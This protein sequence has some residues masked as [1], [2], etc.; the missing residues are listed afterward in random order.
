MEITF[1]KIPYED[2]LAFFKTRAELSDEDERWIRIQYDFMKEPSWIRDNRYEIYCPDNISIKKGAPFVIP[3]GFK[4][5]IDKSNIGEINCYGL[6]E[7]QQLNKDNLVRHIVIAGIATSN[8]C[9][10][11]GDKL[12]E[13]KIIER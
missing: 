5:L 9:F 6:S 13:L 10:Q 7:T 2:Y 1:E 4:C 3:T 11:V 8:H 12:V